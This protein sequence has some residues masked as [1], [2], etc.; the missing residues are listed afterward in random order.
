MKAVVLAGGSGERFWP[1]STR[2]TPKQFL[3]L[4]GNAPLLV[5]TCRRLEQRFEYEDILVITS[6]QHVKRTAKA[7]PQL[8]L[9]NI[10]GEPV[11]KNT[12]PAC[13]LAALISNPEEVNL[14][15][16]ADHHI[17]EPEGFW[18]SFDIALKSLETGGGLHTFGIHA[19]RPETGYGYIEAGEE[20]SDGVRR[21]RRFVE[22]PDL[23]TAEGFLD[24]GDFFWNSGMFLWKA[25]EFLSELSKCSE[26]IFKPMSGLDPR[27][28]AQIDRVYPSLPGR[29]VDHAVM[30]RSKN[31]KMVRGGFGW[32][33]VGNWLSLKELEGETRSGEGLVLVDSEDLYIR[34]EM[35]R[36]I[37]VVGLSGVIIVD[38]REGLLVC[39]QYDVQKVRE[40]SKK[41]K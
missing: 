38:T 37:G 21:V 12:A 14:V 18:R 26:D 8:P 23:R 34:S 32:S 9:E 41:L 35:K 40:I 30:E 5:E 7:L 33:D 27:D 15:V 11:Q 22:K 36:P 29:S 19:T 4:F 28:T 3:K 6:F 1:L 20:I 24:A 2:D 10:I 25:G 13:A 31:V 39:S 17:P 16:P